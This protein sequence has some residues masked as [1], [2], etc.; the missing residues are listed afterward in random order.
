MQWLREGTDTHV[1]V[2]VLLHY[3]NGNGVFY[4][5][6]AEYYKQ[7]ESSSRVESWQFYSEVCEE[8]NL[9][10]LKCSDIWSV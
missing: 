2:E 5:V 8:K 4:D 10:V 9:C 3:N 6:H 7:D 1:T